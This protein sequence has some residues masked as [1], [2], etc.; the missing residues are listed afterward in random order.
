MNGLIIAHKTF[1]F[2][3][4]LFLQLQEIAVIFNFYVASNE[5]IVMFSGRSLRIKKFSSVELAEILRRI[6][7]LLENI[8]EWKADTSSVLPRNKALYGI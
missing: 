4:F 8:V 6:P 5:D 7:D 2:F 1:F 3:L